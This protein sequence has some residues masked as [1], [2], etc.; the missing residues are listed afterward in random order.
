[1]KLPALV[2]RTF[3]IIEDEDEWNTGEILSPQPWGREEIW[4]RLSSIRALPHFS[5][6]LF[7]YSGGEVS[8]MSRTLPP[9]HIIVTRIRF[10]IKWRLELYPEEVI[11]DNMHAG[12]SIQDAVDYWST[13]EEQAREESVT[14]TSGFAPAQNVHNVDT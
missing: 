9:W 10:P 14:G 13:P 4:A 8:R 12:H 11:Q 5:Q 2:S 3:K 7:S 1:V 6:F